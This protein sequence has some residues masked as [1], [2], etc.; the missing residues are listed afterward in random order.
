MVAQ[1]KSRTE[2]KAE[3]TKHMIRMRYQGQAE[4]KSEANEIILINSHDG[5]SSYSMSGPVP[6]SLSS[7]EPQT[8]Q[9]Q[10]LQSIAR[11]PFGREMCS[12]AQYE[13]RCAP[14]CIAWFS[15]AVWR[16]LASRSGSRSPK[17]V[18]DSAITEVHI[19]LRGFM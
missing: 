11:Y 17:K 18:I 8:H 14:R 19:E 5:A 9:E 3:F 16:C 13:R 6:R 2:G 15:A 4:A 7:E 1:G 10:H 12:P